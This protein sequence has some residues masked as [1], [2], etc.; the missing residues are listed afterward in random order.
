MKNRF[1]LRALLAL[2]SAAVFLSGCSLF[3]NGPSWGSK[4]DADKAAAVPALPEPAP[5]HR[6]E[7]DATTDIVGVVQKTLATKEDTLTD[8]ARRFN[9]GYEEIVRANPG[10]DPW[11]PGENR[12]IVI[13]VAVHPAQRAARGHRHQ[14]RRHASLLLPEGEEG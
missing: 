12:E 13:P 3:G 4:R 10:V 8:I 5:T 7:I 6:F 2:A 11:L 9:V 1:V 14:R